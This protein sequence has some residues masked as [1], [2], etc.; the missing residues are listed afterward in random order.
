MSKNSVKTE[1]DFVSAKAVDHFFVICYTVN[2]GG[3]RCSHRFVVRFLNQ[4]VYDFLRVR[5]FLTRFLF[6]CSLVFSV[7]S[8]KFVRQKNNQIY[9]AD[10][11]EL[12]DVKIHLTGADESDPDPLYTLSH[13]G[14]VLWVAR[15]QQLFAIST[16]TGQHLAQHTLGFVPAA[17]ESCTVPRG[18]AVVVAGQ[19]KM[20]IFRTHTK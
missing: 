12:S 13:T 7:R 4:N 18:A 6:E 20:E 8:F 14:T 5:A 9:K 16:R 15:G 17:L 2:D 3:T 11:G 1:G 19:Q 10:V